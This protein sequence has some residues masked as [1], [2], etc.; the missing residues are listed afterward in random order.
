MSPTHIPRVVQGHCQWTF[1]GQGTVTYWV[2]PGALLTSGTNAPEVGV[3]AQWFEAGSSGILQAQVAGGML[4]VLTAFGA[5]AL[6]VNQRLLAV[7]FAK[8]AIPRLR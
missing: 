4:R 6:A 2:E 8:A 7:G 1:V 5:E 3:P